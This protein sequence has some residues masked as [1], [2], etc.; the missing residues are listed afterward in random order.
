MGNMISISTENFIKA[1]YNSEHREGGGSKTGSIARELGITSAAATD[2]AQ[3]LAMKK[4]IDYKKYKELKLTPAGRKMALGIIRKHR[5]WETFLHEVFGLT[6]YE[7][8]REAEMLEHLTSDFLAEKM[9]LYL[10]NPSTD[11]HGDPIP[12]EQGEVLSDDYCLRLSSAESGKEYK[13]SRLSGTDREFFEFCHS[14]QLIVGS[15]LAVKKQYDKSSMTEIEISSA[16]LL[17]NAELANSI[18]VS[19]IIKK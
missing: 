1:I 8:H 18:Y 5:L 16:K 15:T 6:M 14:N 17:L 9:S 19:K 12:S 7:V 13:I 4:L 2:M 3:K 11:P 10:G